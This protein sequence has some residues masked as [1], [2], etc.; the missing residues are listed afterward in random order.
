MR[1][2]AAGVVSQDE[3]GSRFKRFKLSHI[4]CPDISVSHICVQDRVWR[5]GG[6]EG[7][8]MAGET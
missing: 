7:G 6:R 1:K 8:E 3:M 2:N 4:L 5:E